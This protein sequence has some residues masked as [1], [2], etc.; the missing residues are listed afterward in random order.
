MGSYTEYEK[1]TNTE[2]ERKMWFSQLKK[3]VE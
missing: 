3:E 2:E 1:E